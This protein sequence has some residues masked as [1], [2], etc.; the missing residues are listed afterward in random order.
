MWL[1][2]QYFQKPNIGPAGLLPEPIVPLFW[3]AWPNL[4]E[5][6]QFLWP[7]AQRSGST[8][9]LVRQWAELAH[10]FP[11]LSVAAGRTGNL[12][13]LP[14]FG[15]RALDFSQYGKVEGVE[16]LSA[17]GIRDSHSYLSNWGIQR[18]WGGWREMAVAL[19]RNQQ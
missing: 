19:G 4:T 2:M 14:T 9:R 15:Y 3:G 1:S 8:R 10:W 17:Q 5:A 6:E 16:S 13:I 12:G 11:S 18:V 7:E